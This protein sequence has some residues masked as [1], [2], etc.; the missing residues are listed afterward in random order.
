ASVPAGVLGATPIF[1]IPT[2]TDYGILGS[3]I[4]SNT[5]FTFALDVAKQNGVA[6]VLAEPNLTALSGSKAEFLA[7]G[8]FPIPVP[9]DDGITIEYK[10]Y[11]V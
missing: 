7:G 11:G 4:D 9:D 1:D 3:F 10:E 5:L 2:S 8:E 6:K